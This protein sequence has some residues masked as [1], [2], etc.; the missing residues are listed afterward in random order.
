MDYS[1]KNAREGLTNPPGILRLAAGTGDSIAEALEDP[2]T[3]PAPIVLGKDI[4]DA[5]QIDS[6]AACGA[7]EREMVQAW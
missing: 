4:L 3:V 6:T 7:H 1:R 2:L 5:A